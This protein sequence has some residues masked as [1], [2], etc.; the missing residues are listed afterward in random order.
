VKGEKGYKTLIDIARYYFEND[1]YDDF[2]QY[3][4][5]GQ[6]FIQ[7]WTAHLILEYGQPD[8]KLKKRCLD[9]IINYT[10]N[11][12]APD[13]SIQEKKWLESYFNSNA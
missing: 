6:Y 2:A 12:L 9:E 11:P 4:M 1:L 13:V 7:L 10:D 5:E 8:L 3:F